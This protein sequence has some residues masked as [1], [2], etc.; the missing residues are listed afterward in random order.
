MESAALLAAKQGVLGTVGVDRFYRLHTALCVIQ[1][2]QQRV[3]PAS[4]GPR[5]TF[6]MWAQVQALEFGVRMRCRIA[7]RGLQDHRC[8]ISRLIVR[9]LFL[10]VALLAHCGYPLAVRLTLHK[11][12][13]TANIGSPRLRTPRFPVL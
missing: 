11:R 8:P 13:G 7:R 1:R 10:G 9:S 12:Q 5:S 4:L 6:H 3:G 2:D